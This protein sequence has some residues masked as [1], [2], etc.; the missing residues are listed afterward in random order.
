MLRLPCFCTLPLHAVHPTSAV[1]N[2]QRQSA[3]TSASQPH[4]HSLRSLPPELGLMTTLRNVPLDGNPLKLIRRELWAG[5]TAGCGCFCFSTCVL[6]LRATIIQTRHNPSPLPTPHTK[7]KP[8]TRPHLSTARVFALPPPRPHHPT[9]RRPLPTPCS[10]QLP[11]LPLYQRQLR[12]CTDRQQRLQQQRRCSHGAHT[13]R[14]GF[15]RTAARAD[16]SRHCQ[17]VDPARPGRECAHW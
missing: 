10:R 6:L 5:A 2:L 3:L 8:S 15:D 13:A 1:L 11:R 16:R 12:G 4:C 9:R 17:C 7:I 14:Q